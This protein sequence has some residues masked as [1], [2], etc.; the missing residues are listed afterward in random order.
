MHELALAQ[1]GETLQLAD[2][3]VGQ[4]IGQKRRALHRIDKH[5]ELLQVEWAR[6][7]GPFLAAALVDVESKVAKRLQVAIDGLSLGLEV[8]IGEL[9]DDLLRREPVRAVG[10]FHQGFK[11][12]QKPELLIW[13]VRHDVSFRRQRISRRYKTRPVIGTHCS[14]CARSIRSNKSSKRTKGR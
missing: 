4:F 13:S 3:M 2:K 9:L 5:D 7:Q 12:E 10:L 8:V 6:S 11:Q 14:A 1:A